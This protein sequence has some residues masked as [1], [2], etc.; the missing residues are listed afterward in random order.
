MFEQ[1]T[2]KAAH[3]LKQAKK[4]S[5][6]LGQNYVGTEH[7]LI[8]LLR[9]G[10]CAAAELLAERKVEESTVEELIRQLISPEGGVLLQERSGFTPR[11]E[12]VL[13]EAQLEAERFHE[14]KAGTE[15]I[16]IAMLKDV[17][18]AASRL[19]NT[20]DVNVK[21]LYSALLDSMG[22]TGRIYREEAGRGQN[23]HREGAGPADRGRNRTGLGTWKT[24][25]DPGSL[26]HGG[27][28]QVPG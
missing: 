25:Y 1:Y 28:H 18:C 17:E 24:A 10:G 16:L 7:I 23:S 2:E 12:K 27:R 6:E 13:E 9:E 14:E 5:A 3:V 22:R 19:L 21:E 4:V 15:H 26:G 11:A 8:A 20:M